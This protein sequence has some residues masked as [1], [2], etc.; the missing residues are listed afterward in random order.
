MWYTCYH[1]AS[2]KASEESPEPDERVR[3]IE[4]S[5]QLILE[6]TLEAIHWE[7]LVS[8]SK[9]PE[10]SSYRGRAQAF[11]E[12]AYNEEVKL[13]NLESARGAAE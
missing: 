11:R 6:L 1:P 12:A 8:E 5:K 3:L 9:E 13:K 7:E 4:S 2:V 10:R